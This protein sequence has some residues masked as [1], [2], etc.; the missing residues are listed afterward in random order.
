MADRAGLLTLDEEE[1]IARIIFAP[2]M[3]LDG[4]ISPSAFFLSV[5][6]DG[7]IEEYISVWRLAL[8]IPSRQTVRFAP[9]KSGDS[10]YGYARLEVADCHHTVVRDYGCRV[11]VNPRSPNQYHAGI[12]YTGYAPAS[13]GECSDPIFMMLASRLAAVSTLITV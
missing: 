8:K 5:M 2:S 4:R 3:I 13:V 12:Y 10:L 6:K 7:T 11:K 1:K 9:R